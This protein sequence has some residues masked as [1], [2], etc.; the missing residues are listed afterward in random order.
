MIL[1]YTLI[2]STAFSVM[3][4]A[5]GHFLGQDYIL[6]PL[7]ERMGFDLD[8][9]DP[10]GAG[11]GGG[12]INLNILM[13]MFPTTV[14]IWKDDWNVP[15]YITIERAAVYAEEMRTPHFCELCGNI[16]VPYLDLLR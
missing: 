4:C 7:G 1:L 16:H 2:F 9:L 15:A 5:N 8:R 12:L 11:N 3:L 13:A 6:K 10:D 14:G